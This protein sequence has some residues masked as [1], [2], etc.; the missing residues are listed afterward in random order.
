M[1]LLAARPAKRSVV[2]DRSCIVSVWARD[3]GLEKRWSM[4]VRA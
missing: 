3:G 2:A 1:G 4:L